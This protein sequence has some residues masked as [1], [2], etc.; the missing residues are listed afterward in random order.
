MIEPAFWPA[1]RYGRALGTSSGS[2][3]SVTPNRTATG[4]TPT[5]EASR[6]RDYVIRALNKDR[7][8]DQFLAEQ[9]AGDELAARRSRAR[10]SAW[11]SSG[12]GGYEHDQPNVRGQSATILN[13]ITNVTGDVFLGLGISCAHCHDHEFDPILQQTTTASRRSSS[14]CSPRDDL[15]A[16][17][18]AE[19]RPGTRRPRGVGGEDGPDPRGSPR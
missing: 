8:Y 3:S 9:I 16:A 19:L 5:A 4:R 15:M 7:P 17:T 6:Y 18:A 14:P 11:G 13:D 2:T 12:L 10:W 1:P